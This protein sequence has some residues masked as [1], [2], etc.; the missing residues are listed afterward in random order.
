MPNVTVK[1]NESFE[2][3]WRR[4]KR[5]TERAGIPRR[6]REIEFHEKPTS[7]RKRE[8]AAAKKRW[9]KKLA[10]EEENRLRGRIIRSR[11]RIVSAPAESQSKNENAQD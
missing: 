10:K 4:L 2:S 3:A 7:K 8:D 9:H 11:R 6:L 5:I 1:D